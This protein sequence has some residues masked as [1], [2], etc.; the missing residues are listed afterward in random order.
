MAKTGDE[1]VKRETE[2]FYEYL[3]EEE[4]KRKKAK[5]EETIGGSNQVAASLSG[6]G[7]AEVQGSRGGVPLE[8]M[9]KGKVDED[10]QEQTEKKSR[11]KQEKR[12]MRRS[13]DVGEKYTKDLRPAQSKERRRTRRRRSGMTWTTT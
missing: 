2:R 6:G 8:I 4:N 7:G 3:E 9:N 5:T 1:R 12:G 13:R 10:Q 11:S